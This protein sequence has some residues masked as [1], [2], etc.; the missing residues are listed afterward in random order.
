MADP[1]LIARLY[2]V[3]T[4]SLAKST[5]QLN[6]TRVR[7][8]RSSFDSPS[9]SEGGGSALGLGDR[10]STQA[11]EDVD[12]DDYLDCLELRFSNG[13]RTSR[14][15][16]FGR[17]EKC[18]IVLASQTRNA[19]SH[20][21]AITFEN[22]FEDTDKCR[23][24]LRDLNSTFG[25]AVQYAGRGGESRRGFRWILS[26]HAGVDDSDVVVQASLLLQFRIVVHIKE[27][28]HSLVRSVEHFL[29]ERPAESLL[30]DLGFRILPRTEAPTGAHTPKSGPILLSMGEL[31][32]GA[33]GVATRW[34]DVSTGREF[35]RKRPLLQLC[36]EDR[37]AWREEAKLLRKLSHEHI[38]KIFGVVETPHPVFGN[39]AP[40]VEL[41]L[42]C[43]LGG[44]LDQRLPLKYVDCL[45]VTCQGLSALAYLHGHDPPIVHRDIKPQ[46]ILIK[47]GPRGICIKLA[48]F[49]LSREDRSLTTICGTRLYFAPEI[50]EEELWRMNG[51][52]SRS[53]SPAVD[54]W[55]LGVVILECVSGL[56][57]FNAYTYQWCRDI[58]G[59]TMLAT[60]Q[61]DAHELYDFLLSRMLVL[62][63]EARGSAQQCHDQVI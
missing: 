60:W 13:P 23:L 8:G 63:P 22:G 30:A 32:R 15:F 20:H 38:V 14:G 59:Y 18:D 45:D 48:D 55:S 37:R 58:I 24:V 56:P 31:G 5:F 3:A 19:S 29:R 12:P 62:D 33:F 4:N 43:I 26:D 42:E 40:D 51:G 16:V 49:G 10:E 1:D 41:H 27:I 61:P 35:A 11:P 53:Y 7:P 50:A 36:E 47:D 9:R 2:P 28:S 25:T 34:W 39:A 54:I 46:N 21:F 44:T 17:D 57:T 6:Q 52:I